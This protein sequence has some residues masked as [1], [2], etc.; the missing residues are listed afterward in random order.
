MIC[1]QP[2]RNRPGGLSGTRDYSLELSLFDWFLFAG[3]LAQL[4]QCRVHLI[5]E[6]RG[7]FNGKIQAQ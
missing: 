4:I 3:W 7:S 1:N 5:N 2:L 6:S